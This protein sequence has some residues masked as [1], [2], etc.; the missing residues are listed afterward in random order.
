MP[1]KPANSGAKQH[2]AKNIVDPT[3]KMPKNSEDKDREDARENQGSI[4]VRG[5]VV[6]N[7]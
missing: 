5:C 4:E 3:L 7:F 1:P 6:I 2:R